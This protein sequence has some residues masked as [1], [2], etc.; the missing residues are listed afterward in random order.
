[1]SW[2]Y[3]GD[4]RTVSH[5]WEPAG[6]RTLTAV[7]L[8]FSGD[9]HSECFS[10]LFCFLHIKSVPSALICGPRCSF[11]WRLRPRKAGSWVFEGKRQI[12]VTWGSTRINWQL[13]GKLALVSRVRVLWRVKVKVKGQEKMREGGEMCCSL[14]TET[15]S[16]RELCCVW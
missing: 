5:T 4:Q 15:F 16:L 8:W 14:I 10:L 1:M 12:C 6:H 3:V 9:T 13:A 2:C 7:E 11:L